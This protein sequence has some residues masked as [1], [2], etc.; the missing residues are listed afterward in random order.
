MNLT[1][2]DYIL[3]QG[4]AKL[5]RASAT[6]RHRHTM[7]DRDTGVPTATLKLDG[8]HASGA[9]S[10]LMKA[11]DSGGLFGTLPLGLTLTIAGTDYA[12]TTE[13]TS[14]TSDRITATIGS[15]GLLAEAADEAAVTLGQYVEHSHPKVN[16]RPADMQDVQHLVGFGEQVTQAAGF[17]GHLAP[18]WV[19]PKDLVEFTCANGVVT[20][21]APARV[22]TQHGWGQVV[23]V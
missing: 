4:V 8:I 6:V 1:G 12:T 13:A 15:P 23:F 3:S 20:P 9:V 7:A 17:P 22:V 18:A 2:R 14:T 21:Q 11:P 5:A 16:L 10:L 19:S